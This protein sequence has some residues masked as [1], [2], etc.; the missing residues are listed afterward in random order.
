MNAVLPLDV[1]FYFF[2]FSCLSVASSPFLYSL[3]LLWV[4]IFSLPSTRISY[5]VG[6]A[7]FHMKRSRDIWFYYL[8][9]FLLKKKIVPE[10]SHSRLVYWNRG[11][12]VS[13]HNHLL[14]VKIENA[15]SEVLSEVFQQWPST[16]G[17]LILLLLWNPQVRLLK[18]LP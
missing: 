10:K 12:P 6:R 7:V 5:E 16:E 8:F 1:L 18:C 3:L 2:L 9:Q 15:S 13:L 17:S 4:C 14:V 11:L